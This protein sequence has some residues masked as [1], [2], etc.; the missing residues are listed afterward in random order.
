MGRTATLAAAINSATLPM[1]C[2]REKKEIPTDRFRL[3]KFSSF[4][5]SS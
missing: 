3:L 1:Y 5:A 4:N 2:P